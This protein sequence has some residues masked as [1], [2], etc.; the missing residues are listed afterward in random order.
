M[1]KR[2]VLCLAAGFCVLAACSRKPQEIPVETIEFDPA[3]IQMFV[4]D[5]QP[6]TI[7]CYPQNATNLDQL[8]TGNSDPAVAD[9]QDGLLTARAAGYTRLQATCGNASAFANVNVYA[10]W[11]TKNEAKYGVDLAEGHYYMMGESSP[12]T[13]DLTL[14]HTQADGDTQN[15]WILFPCS[16]LGKTINFLEDMTDCMAAVYMNNNEDGY[17][18]AY[19][20]EDLGRP[21]IVTADWSAT[22]AT[23]TKGLLTVTDLGSKKYK[24]EADFALSNGYTFTASWEGTP[25]MKKEG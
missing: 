18:V 20:S 14:S 21:V 11:F 19:Y 6:V 22:D 7:K 9:F 5:Q 16:Q 25:S 1:K 10:G 15:F 3:S 2:I 24:V 12:V 8:Y 23:L 13:M 17:T 4:G